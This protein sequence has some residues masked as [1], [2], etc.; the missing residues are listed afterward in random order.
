MFITS[1]VQVDTN[2]L[3]FEN[4]IFYRSFYELFK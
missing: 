1:L 4:I 3:L 2:I